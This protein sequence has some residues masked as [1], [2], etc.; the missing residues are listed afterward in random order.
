VVDHDA[1]DSTVRCARQPTGRDLAV[2]V[3]EHLRGCP[4]CRS[5]RRQLGLVD[6]F[7]APDE[8]FDYPGGRSAARWDSSSGCFDDGKRPR[9]LP[10]VAAP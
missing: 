8:R 4:A 3:E 10:I 2:A 5:T 1:F 6:E 7:G 9:P